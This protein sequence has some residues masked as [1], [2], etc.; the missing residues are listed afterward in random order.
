MTTLT[1][2]GTVTFTGRSG[3]K[4]DFDVYDYDVLFPDVAAVYTVTKATPNSQGGRSHDALYVGETDNLRKRLGSHHKE[5]CFKRN[6]A[7]RKCIRL[8]N[9]RKKRL[10]IEADLIAAKNPVCND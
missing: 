3:N 8:E 9:D 2:L 6:G 4:Y 1:R 5:S 7:N 10:A